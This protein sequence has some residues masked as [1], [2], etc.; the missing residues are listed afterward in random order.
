MKKIF[1]SKNL[2][3]VEQALHIVLSELNRNE[4]P[5]SSIN[6]KNPIWCS[7]PEVI[8]RNKTHCTEAKYL[9]ITYF[10]LC[11]SSWQII[12]SLLQQCWRQKYCNTYA[13]RIHY[14]F[15]VLQL[16]GRKAII[17]MKCEEII[18][19]LLSIEI[20][21]INSFCAFLIPLVLMAFPSS[22]NIFY[23]HVYSQG[24]IKDRNL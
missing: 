6:L 16:W 15:R 17:H 21:N 3:L 5:F 10:F 4:I 18:F 2:L 7:Q 12:L 11:A 9:W 13:Q 23:A 1:W 19:G 20:N 22:E 24:E 14:T 8:S